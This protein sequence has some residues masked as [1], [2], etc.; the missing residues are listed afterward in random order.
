[1]TKRKI[2]AYNFLDKTSLKNRA[3]VTTSTFARK[4]AIFRAF[5]LTA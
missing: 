3:K 1:M 4:Y 2:L 5:Y